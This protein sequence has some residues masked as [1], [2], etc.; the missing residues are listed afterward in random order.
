[1]IVSP[2]ELVKCRLQLQTEASDKAYYKGPFD[3]VK[4][5]V[6]EEGF[7]SLFNGMVSTVLREIPAYGGQFTAYFLAKRFWA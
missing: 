6:V 4:K 2:I 1:M 7:I 5:I 3:C